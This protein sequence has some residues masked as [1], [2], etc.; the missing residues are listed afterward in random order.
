MLEKLYLVRHGHIDTKGQ[1][2]Y[3]GRTDLPLDALGFEQVE[4]LRRYFRSIPIQAAFTS[5]LIRC[6]ETVCGICEDHAITYRVVEDLV[7]INMGEWENVAMA[8]IEEDFPALYAKRGED[9]EYFT[10]PRGENFH[11]VA[12]RVYKAFDDIILHASGT[13]LIVAHAGVNRV[14]LCHLLGVSLHDMLQ[15]EQP[16]ACINVLNWDAS[17]MQWTCTRV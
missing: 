1:R 6:L 15:I 14:I 13:G 10:P 4:R 17:K 5:P 16:Y 11:Q 9:L 2:R 8:K 7:E 12:E 3:I